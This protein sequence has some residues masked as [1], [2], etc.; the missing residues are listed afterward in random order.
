MKP[1]RKKGKNRWHKAGRKITNGNK[2]FQTSASFLLAGWLR[3]LGLI[4]YIK[5]DSN[6][7]I[8]FTVHMSV[9]LDFYPRYKSFCVVERNGIKCASSYKS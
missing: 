8:Q 5:F 2:R 6:H 9:K 7:E 3:L 4:F 1:E